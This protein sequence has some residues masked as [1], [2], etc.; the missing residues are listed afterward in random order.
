MN[1]HI[2][3]SDVKILIDPDDYDRVTEHKWYIGHGRTTVRT[4]SVKLSTS[5]H[6]FITGVTEKG[7]T[8]Y[9]INGNTWDNRKVNLKVATNGEAIVYVKK[10]NRS[11][12]DADH[13]NKWFTRTKVSFL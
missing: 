6:K 12:E 5:L 13:A 7:M 9:H 4:K 11:R 3:I 1:D 8:A 2:M 10:F